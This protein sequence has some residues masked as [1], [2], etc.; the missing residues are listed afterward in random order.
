MSK[1]GGGNQYQ[2]IPQATSQNSS[3]NTNQTTNQTQNTQANGTSNQNTSQLNYTNALQNAIQNAIN[4]QTSS[5]NT[6]GTSL[7]NVA[8]A[9]TTFSNIPVWLENAAQSGIGAAQG[10]LNNPGQSYGGPLT[11]GLNDIQQQAGNLYQN[12]VDQFSPYFD[13]AKQTIQSGLQSAPQINAQTLKNGLSGISDYMNPYINNV[14]DNISKIGQQNLDNALNQTH[15][16]AIASKAFGGSRQGVQEGVATA[17]NNLNTNNLIANTLNQGYNNATNML[18][19]DVQNNLGA[20]QS[21]QNSYQNYLNNLLSGGGAIANLGTSAQNSLNAGIGNLLNYGNLAQTTNQNANTAAYN[22]WMRQQNLPYQ[23]QQLYNSSVSSA[24]HSTA[25]TST[26]NQTSSNTQNQISNA[27]QNAISQALSNQSNQT[28]QVGQQNATG[29][30][31]NTSNTNMTGNTTGNTNT[32]SS[33]FSM[34]PVQQTS[35]SPIMQGIGGL[36]GLGSLFA[37]P[38]GGTSAIGGMGSALS[39]LAGGIGSAANWALNGLGPLAFSVASDK[40][41]KTD[42]KKIGKDEETGLDIYSY[43]YKGDPKTYPK[44]VGPMAQDIEEYYP[45]ATKR[46]GNRLTV[47]PGAFNSLAGKFAGGEASARGL[48]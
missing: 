39:G 10:L 27:I 4:N 23:A 47:H 13:Q 34:M 24:P 37:S 45:Q 28:T 2:Y 19:Q 33:G 6:S 35:S 32:N 1:G 17:Q 15:D 20:Q 43:R 22:E 48:L 8:N 30:T 38:A 46:Q 16:Q 21:N 9:G 44:V 29:N 5:S 31:S 36:M 14:V 18:S 25:Q 12:S 26:S 41:L 40:D 3:T 11:A 7:G 42:I